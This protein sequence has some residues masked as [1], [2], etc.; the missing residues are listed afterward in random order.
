MKTFPVPVPTYFCIKFCDS[1]PD[2]SAVTTETGNMTSWCCA[3][4]NT[5]SSIIINVCHGNESL[6][7]SAKVEL[8]RQK[9]DSCSGERKEIWS[10]MLLILVTR[11]DKKSELL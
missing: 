8:L 7:Y 11:Q 1:L 9:N 4:E 2:C 10:K 6:I 3:F 5:S